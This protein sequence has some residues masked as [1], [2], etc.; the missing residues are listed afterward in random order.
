MGVL[1]GSAQEQTAQQHD[2][3]FVRAGRE[4]FKALESIANPKNVTEQPV[5]AEKVTVRGHEGGEG[6]RDKRYDAGHFQRNIKQLLVKDHN[7][8]L[9]LAI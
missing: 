2:A 7:A 1:T 5:L 9:E 4:H 6:A 3:V 8:G